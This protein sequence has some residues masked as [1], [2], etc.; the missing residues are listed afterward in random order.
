MR[1]SQVNKGISQ[2]IFYVQIHDTAFRQNPVVL[3][4]EFSPTS[5]FRVPRLGEKKINLRG[6]FK[7]KVEF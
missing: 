5:S 3:T 4:R 7:K 2:D 1:C 6:L